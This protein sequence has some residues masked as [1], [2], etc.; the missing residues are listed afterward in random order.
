MFKHINMLLFHVPIYLFLS[1]AI[2]AQ[3]ITEYKLKEIVTSASRVP[4]EFSN[5]SRSVILISPREIQS[6]PST[7][8]RTCLNMHRVLTCAHA[9]LRGYRP[10]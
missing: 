2:F 6:A 10:I 3:D 9:A 1:G 5:L 7:R 4:V 8:F